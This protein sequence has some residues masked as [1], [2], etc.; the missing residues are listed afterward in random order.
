MAAA[1][2]AGTK[3]DN[4]RFTGVLMGEKGKFDD[5]GNNPSIQSGVFGYHAGA[6]T[7]ALRTDGTFTLQG[8]NANSQTKIEVDKDGELTIKQRSTNPNAQNGWEEFSSYVKSTA[9]EYAQSRT[10]VV[11]NWYTEGLGYKID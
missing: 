2:A 9:E 5:N 8:G 1:Y 11:N 7:F 6:E 3:D 4:N 10:Q